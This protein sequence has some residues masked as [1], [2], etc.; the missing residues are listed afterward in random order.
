MIINSN[1]LAADK[2]F[3]ILATIRLLSSDQIY[4]PLTSWKQL[5]GLPSIRLLASANNRKVNR[6]EQKDVLCGN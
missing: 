2:N 4:R 3:V 1:L 6:K 5:I